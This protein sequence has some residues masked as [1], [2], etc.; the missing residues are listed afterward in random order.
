MAMTFTAVVALVICSQF[1]TIGYSTSLQTPRNPL[2]GQHLHVIW[3]I[4]FILSL[5]VKFFFFNLKFPF[6][7]SRYGVATLKDWRDR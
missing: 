2:N 5:K 4:Y 3:V 7:F 6:L 1:W